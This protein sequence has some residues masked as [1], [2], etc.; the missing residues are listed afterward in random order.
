MRLVFLG[1]KSILIINISVK[2]CMVSYSERICIFG[3]GNISLHPMQ[4]FKKLLLLQNITYIFFFHR[5]HTD[6]QQKHGR[7]AQHH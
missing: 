5:R 6:D 1:F 4:T 2:Y 3:L 7:Y